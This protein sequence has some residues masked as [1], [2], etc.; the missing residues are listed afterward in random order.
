MGLLPWISKVRN[1]TWKHLRGGYVPRRFWEGWGDRFPRLGFQREIYAGQRWLLERLRAHAG[2]P[3]LEVGCGFGRNL[4]YLA[5]N[6]GPGGTLWGLDI[7]SKMLRQARR[8]LPAGCHLA[9]GDI[10]ALPFPDGGFGLVFTHGVLMH[11]RPESLA[12]ALAEIRRVSSSSFLF[13]E[14]TYWPGLRK[15]DSLKLNDYTYIHDYAAILPREGFEI[16]EM[17]ESGEAVNMI[18]IRC[19]KK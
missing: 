19:R 10:Q 4:D 12:S 14:E 15:G 13:A 9:C 6:L 1:R 16:E 11:V 8:E 3:I 2:A 18:L 5:R 17:G 7:S